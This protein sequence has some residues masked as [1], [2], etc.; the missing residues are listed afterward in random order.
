MKTIKIQAID[1]DD[2]GVRENEILVSRIVGWYSRGRIVERPGNPILVTTTTLISLDS[3]AEYE[4]AES[5]E[6]FRSRLTAIVDLPS[7]EF[8]G[9]RPAP[10]F[11][12]APFQLH[13]RCSS[14][15][16]PMKT[17]QL[18]FLNVNHVCDVMV[19]DPAAPNV[20]VCRDCVIKTILNAFRENV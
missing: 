9:F 12:P 17:L 18:S 4:I 10:P 5:L 6:S 1:P 11:S 20:R 15:S 2:Q 14:C 3:G 8:T 7:Y 16:G 13:P 19:E